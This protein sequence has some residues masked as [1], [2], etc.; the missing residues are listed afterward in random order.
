[1][2]SQWVPFTSVLL[3]FLFGTK[4]LTDLAILTEDRAPAFALSPSHQYT[5]LHAQLFT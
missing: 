4:S 1:M 2:L 5:Y 3:F